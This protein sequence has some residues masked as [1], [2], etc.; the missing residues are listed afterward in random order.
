MSAKMAA[1]GIRIEI[2]T[3]V[4]WKSGIEVAATLNAGRL[5]HQRSVL[6]QAR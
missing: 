6:I 1:N 3:D 5:S 2:N 4:S